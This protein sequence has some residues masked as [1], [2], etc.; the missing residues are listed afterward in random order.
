MV[1]W[2]IKNEYHVQSLLY[3]IL[4]PLFPSIDDE[5]YL[6]KVGQKQP[7]A[8]IAIP[9]IKLLIEV[10]FLRDTDS[11]QKVIDEI[12]SDASLYLAQ[13][14]PYEAVLPFVWDDGRRVE[15]HDKLMEGLGK[16]RGIVHPIVV[17]RPGRMT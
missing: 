7:R 5:L 15:Q 3:A 4:A 2:E 6:I 1:R 12:A 17:A 10:K 8:D 16:L 11:F 9:S 14:S 13:G